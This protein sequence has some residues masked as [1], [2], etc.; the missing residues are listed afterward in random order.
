MDEQAVCCL[1]ERPTLLGNT[2]I[3][4]GPTVFIASGAPALR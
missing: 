1:A 4:F 3:G 2:N